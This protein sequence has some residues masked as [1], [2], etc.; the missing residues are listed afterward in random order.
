LTKKASTN[1][2]EKKGQFRIGG[3]GKGEKKKNG[4]GHESSGPKKAGKENLLS[5]ILGGNENVRKAGLGV[6]KERET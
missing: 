5:R 3:G 6:A 2:K 1:G 4:A